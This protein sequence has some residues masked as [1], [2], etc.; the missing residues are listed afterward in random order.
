MRKE[1]L[2]TVSK[3]IMYYCSLLLGV[4]SALFNVAQSDSS[5]IKKIGGSLTHL[6][7]DRELQ[8]K[9]K[10]VQVASNSQLSCKNDQA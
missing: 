7:N 6:K 4:L 2:A 5:V 8:L 1:N 10:K 3:A 9:L